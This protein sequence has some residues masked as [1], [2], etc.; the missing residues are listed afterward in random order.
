M[1]SVLKTTILTLIL[2]LA[3]SLAVF[4]AIRLSGGDVTAARL[5]ASATTADRELFRTAAR[6]LLIDSQGDPASP[7][8]E[9][10][11]LSLRAFARGFQGRVRDLIAAAMQDDGFLK[12]LSRDMTELGRVAERVDQAKLAR[13]GVV[14]LRSVD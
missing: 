9:A 4:A 11:L 2:L 8:H 10:R 1:K 14:L 5:P 12:L 7:A 13:S 3:S 6:A